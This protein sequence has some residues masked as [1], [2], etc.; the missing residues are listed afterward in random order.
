MTCEH[1]QLTQEYLETIWLFRVPVVDNN[2]RT[3]S[4]AEARQRA[5][6]HVTCLQI[7]LEFNAVYKSVYRPE[8]AP[9]VIDLQRT[10]MHIVHGFAED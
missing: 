3:R 10:E 1:V 9:F 5:Y 4:P 7:K 8:L 6:K 2:W